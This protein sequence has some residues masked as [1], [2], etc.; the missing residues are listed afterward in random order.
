ML[1]DEKE[2]KIW[3][4]LRRRAKEHIKFGMMSLELKIQDGKIVK[5]DILQERISIG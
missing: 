1:A 5:G 3:N 2:E 4:E